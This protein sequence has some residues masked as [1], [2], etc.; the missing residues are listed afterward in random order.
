MPYVLVAIF[1]D[2]LHVGPQFQPGPS[3]GASRTT[4]L[5]GSSTPRSDDRCP[6]CVWLHASIPLDSPALS[7]QPAGVA[8]SQIESFGAPGLDSLIHFPT[9][10]RGPPAPTAA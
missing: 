5:A 3:A 10:P 9:A 7:Q 4:T 6:A 2:F 1:V 8:S